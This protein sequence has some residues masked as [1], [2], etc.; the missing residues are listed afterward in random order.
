MIERVVLANGKGVSGATVR[1]FGLGTMLSARTD[2]QGRYRLPD[3]ARW[4]MGTVV[5]HPDFALTMVSQVP[6]TIALSVGRTITGRVVD[7]HEKPVAG[8]RV[9]VDR[10]GAPEVVTDAEGRFRLPHASRD[11]PRI[12]AR[13]KDSVGVSTIVRGEPTIRLGPAARLGGTVRDAE[14]RP[15][16]GIAVGIF[17]DTLQAIVS[18]DAKGTFAFSGLPHGKYRLFADGKPVYEVQTPD[19]EILVDRDLTR[20]LTAKR[21]PRAEGIVRDESGR[22]VAGA[23]I[24][25]SGILTPI[26]TAADGRFSLAAALNEGKFQISVTKAGF[27]PALGGLS[28]PGKPIEITMRS[29]VA[30]EGTVHGPNGEALAGV[31]LHPVVD[32]MSLRDSAAPWAVSDARGRFAVR[33]LPGVMA[34][35][36]EKK[37]FQTRRQGVEVQEE[38]K[39]LDVAL[40]KALV[41][42]GRVVTKDG[43]PAANVTVLAGL[44]GQM[45]ATT[46]VDGKFEMDVFQTDALE[47]YYGEAMTRK[48]VRL[49]AE[50]LVLVLPATRLVHG[51]VIDAAT[52]APIERFA[53]AGI[54]ED[55]RPREAP[56]FES[57]TGEF[58]IELPE[59][60]LELR[61]SADGYAPK[62]EKVGTATIELTRG[63][64]VRGT[65]TDDGGKPL[66]GVTITAGRSD[67]GLAQSR[68]DGTWEASGFE[69]GEAVRLAFSIEGYVDA[70]RTIAPAAADAQV[71]V[72]MH[73]GI[74]VSGRV[75]N[76]AGEG[77]PSAMVEGSSAAIGAGYPSTQTDE[78]GEFRFNALAPGRYDFTAETME[79]PKLKG[80]LS[81]VDVE[82]TR[83][84]TIR[85]VEKPTGTITGRVVGIDPKAAMRMV[86]AIND[87][88]DTEMAIVGAGGVFRI[89]RV[90]AGTVRVLAQVGDG[91]KMQSSRPKTVEL[92][93]GGSANVELSIETPVALRGRVLRRETGLAG[94][95]LSFSGT[96]WASASATTGDDGTFAVELAPGEYDVEIRADAKAFPFQ[97]H[98]VVDSPSTVD[99]RVDAA[100]VA[101]SATAAGVPLSGVTVIAA[102]KGETHALATAV[103][104]EDGT[105]VMEVGAN[106][107]LTIVG[108]KSGYA[109]ASANYKSSSAVTLAMVPVARAIV[110]LIDAH[111]GR[112]LG[113]YIVAHD[114]SGRVVAHA[115]EEQIDADGSA[116]LP[117]APGKYRFSGSADEYGSQ[118]VTADVPTEGEVRIALPRGG[119]IAMRSEKTLRGSVRLV[120]PN[121]EPYVRCWCS[122]IAETRI[123]GTLTVI[124]AVSPGIY[125]LELMPT[126]GQA[127]RYP[128]IVKEGE[129]TNVLIE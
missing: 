14:K 80:T 17:S 54:R 66:A 114:F 55:E 13:A 86:Q 100:S 78:S 102:R 45:A 8:A 52:R 123:E 38:M 127:R 128:V 118:T 33:L 12:V 10:P 51:R 41:L 21:E 34:L 25:F 35:D 103:T 122:G 129:T 125:T 126:G 5:D 110:R 117:L 72:T 22:P 76:A 121:G 49:P 84:I 15:L 9:A 40:A 63:R 19:D 29:G 61:V 53:V 105:A 73:R 111:D 56:T 95:R 113:G 88:G 68:E 59:E 62:N 71:D 11:E 67:Q 108:S 69:P 27:P 92:A 98:V 99:F 43:A 91:N 120:L 16:T 85:A 81:S 28:A 90:P 79:T 57:S 39:P 30:V 31:A 2:E 107:E 48:E 47:I 96:S 32:G 112:T 106:E 23:R 77:I 60:A 75:V 1:V 50:D 58:A 20:D 4:A 6:P 42:R 37:G 82:K 18:T 65:I 46:D 36:F 109:N 74:A 83:E 116:A 104:G 97:Q 3:P 7:E 119:K 94:A 124:D 64:R 24:A 26:V 70:A 44:P 93:A 101:V 87:E 89:E 115:S